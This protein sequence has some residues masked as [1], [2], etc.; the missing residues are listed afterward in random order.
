MPARAMLPN[1]ENCSHDEL[2]T[3]INATPLKKGY[4][5][6]F[7]IKCLFA[8]IPHKMVAQANSI[9]DRTLYNWIRKF[10]ESGI[11]GLISRSRPGRPRKISPQQTDKYLHLI[12]NPKEAD[13]VHWTA[14][15]FYGYIRDKFDH[16]LSYV[17]VCRW[18]K[19]NNYRLKVPRPWPIKQ[20][21]EAREAFVKQLQT[22]LQDEEIDIWF[23]DEMGVE[24]DPRPRRRWV[25]KKEL[26]LAPYLG[27]HLRLNVTGI[28]C[29]RTGEFYSLIFSH[30]DSVVFQTFLDNANNDLKLHRRR[31]LLILDNASWHKNKS[32]NWGHFEPVF[33]PPYSPD[34]NPIER[35]WL[36]L[37][38]EWFTDFIAKDMKMLTE[39]LCNAL[40]WL[41]NREDKN[42][43][44]C[45]IRK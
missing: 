35:L 37:K 38:A 3:A 6:L 36:I 1:R 9:S 20:D 34:L 15:K 19:D 39:R 28:I 18:L 7:A 25:E 2:E 8:G 17:T 45:R 30:S 43:H 22:Y 26:A 4:R 14:I 32:I 24:G 41:I 21:E 10:N 12:A 23:G 44:T 40:Q 27:M 33:L 5:R 29:P 16:D 42:K 13:Q 11:D 31:N